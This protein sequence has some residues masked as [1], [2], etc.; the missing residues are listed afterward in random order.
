MYG[1]KEITCYIG[2]SLARIGGNFTL[3][4][5]TLHTCSVLMQIYIHRLRC[6]GYP[7]Y[8]NRENRPLTKFITR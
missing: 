4:Y 2:V 3:N 8:I 5:T 1:L 6:D 7:I